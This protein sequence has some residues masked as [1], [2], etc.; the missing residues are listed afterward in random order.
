MT[1]STSLPG[2]LRRIWI[3]AV[4]CGAG[5]LLAM[6]ATQPASAHNYCVHQGYDWGCVRDNH[7][8][9]SA[10]DAEPD[11][12]RVYTE[13]WDRTPNGSYDV[14]TL[15]DWGGADGKCAT[16][17]RNWIDKILV[18]ETGGSAPRACNSTPDRRLMVKR[19][20]A[21]PFMALAAGF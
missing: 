17:H 18:C 3:L 11:G 13:A 15:W 14:Q 5:L 16:S 7:T 2:D 21:A 8:G 1:K 4:S 9:W 12:R 6:I 20:P 10:C 19:D